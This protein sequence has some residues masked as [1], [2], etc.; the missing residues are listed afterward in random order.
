MTAV[1]WIALAILAGSLIMGL[2]RGFV[3]EAFSLAAWIL[4]F[5]AAR[6]FSPALAAHVPGIEQEGLR[7][8]AAIVLIFIGVLVAAQI[9]AAVL[10]KLVKLAGLGGFDRM[11]GMLFGLARASVVLVALTLVAGLTA[12]PR[13]EPWRASLVHGPLELAALKVIPWLPKDLAA[14]IRFA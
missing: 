3:R 6:L 7:Q 5:L 1:D 2:I 11:L 14:L 10:A 8:A 12:L 4:A 9:I 13:S